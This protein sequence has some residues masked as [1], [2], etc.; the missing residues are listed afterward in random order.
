[1]SVLPNGRVSMPAAS[2][3]SR[4]TS[5]RPD[6][7]SR[8]AILAGGGL[9]IKPAELPS[10]ATIRLQSSPRP[11]WP[12]HERLP[13]PWPDRPV[14]SAPLGRRGGR[15][16]A[17]FPIRDR[18][19]VNPRRGTDM[20]PPVDTF[21]NQFPDPDYQIEITYPEFTAVC[22][23]TGQ[24]DFGTIVIHY[25]PDAACLELKSLKL[26]LC[27]YRDRGI[28]YEHAINTILDE[29]VRSCRPRSLKVVGQ[30]NPRGGMT[31]RI[32]ADYQTD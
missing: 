26:Y 1:M 8:P 14:R 29:L 20:P 17:D 23:K 13:A 27:G 15:A 2:P 32:T 12:G 21:P 31:S 25:V 24:P 6:P 9:R 3:R 28:F 19:R 4:S 16:R 22:P 5:D 30:F 18:P 10:G 7:A 11:S